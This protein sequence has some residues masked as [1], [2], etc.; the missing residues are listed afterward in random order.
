MYVV[1]TY[2]AEA[3][4]ESL[5]YQHNDANGRG[6]LEQQPGYNMMLTKYHVMGDFPDLRLMFL[7]THGYFVPAPCALKAEV[8]DADKHRMSDDLPTR[9]TVFASIW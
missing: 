7:C 4:K 5:G 3:K 2:V 1:C 8:D 9:A 6:S